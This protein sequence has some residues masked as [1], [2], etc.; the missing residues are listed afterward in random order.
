MTTSVK[1]T[2]QRWGDGLAVRIPTTLVRSAHFKAGQRVEVPA[3]GPHALIR[4]VGGPRLSL[5]QKLASFDPARHG[6]EAMLTA[7]PVGQETF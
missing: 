7:S 6:G 2:I 1:A 3:R 5:A 4:T